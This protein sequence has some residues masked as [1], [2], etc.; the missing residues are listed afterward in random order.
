MMVSFIRRGFGAAGALL[1]G[2]AVAASAAAQGMYYKEIRKDGRIYVF[3]D[4]KKAD[5]FE[6]SGEVGTGLTRPA[7]GPNGETVVAD[8]EQALDLFFFKYG[9]S[10][11]VER[12]KSPTQK[13][14]W[15]DGKTRITTDKAYLEVS[16][17]VQV[18]YT[19]EMPDDTI[20][21]PGTGDKGDSK[22]SFRIRRA[23][24]KLEGWFYKPE[25]TYEVQM[26]WPA[27]AGS[28]IGAFLE[29]ANITWDVS[30][31]GQFKV[32]FGQNKVAFGHQELT[33]SG[34]QSFVDRAEVSNQF[35]RGRDLGLSVI[36]VLGNNLLEYRA[37]IYNGNGLTRTINDNDQFQ[38]NARV[39]FQLSGNQNMKQRAWSSGVFYSE[40]DFE[41]TDKPI[42]WVAA[43]FE[44]NDFHGVTT[45]VDLKDTVYGFDAGLKYKGVY[46]TGEYYIR[47]RT[48]ETGSEFDSD[49]WFAQ[50]SYLIGSK[51][52]WEIAG[53]Y[54]SWDPS[55][56][57]S[58]NERNEWRVGASYYYNRHNLKVQADYGQL[59]TEAAAGNI[60]NGEFRVQTQFIF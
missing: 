38:Y 52:K 1:L 11:V 23:K 4:A 17:R 18:R 42:I 45:N 33:S 31:K 28:N 26:N 32:V 40:G 37:G 48:P 20:Q 24:F 30:K 59:E 3:N 39:M 51:K 14:E 6:K 58:V 56:A 35:A 29:D 50:A 19:Q 8:S 43:N 49:G 9:I 55:D 60:K 5:A 21:L 53:R 47:E 57:A 34:S 54:G 25:L 10:Q 36:G 13:I 41:S 44:K 15:R 22:G 27:A 7:A 16:N 2:L 12:P 46:L